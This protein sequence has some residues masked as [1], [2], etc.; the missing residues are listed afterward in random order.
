MAMAEVSESLSERVLAAR[1]G[2]RAAFA[3]IVRHE[4]ATLIL[5]A[6]ALVGE[7]HAAEDAAQE[8]LVIAWRKL[9]D[10]HDPARFRPWL[11]T[12]VVRIC[13]RLRRKRPRHASADPDQFPARD[14]P[15]DARLDRLTAEVERLPE[16]FRTPISLFYLAELS[17][18]D[19][20][21]ATG[22]PEKLVKSRLFE[23]RKLLRK[24]METENRP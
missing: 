7:H 6:R 21:S 1:R 18:R 5:T 14:E 11:M 15:E 3:E 10:L 20:A 8:A 24:R 16:K 4:R 2:D 23:A 9:G 12:I 19:V 22:V 13:G 17:Y